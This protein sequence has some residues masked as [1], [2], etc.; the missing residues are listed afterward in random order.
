MQ[1]ESAQAT[2]TSKSSRRRNPT[3]ASY[4]GLG[5]ADEPTHLVKYAPTPN[6][7]PPP[8]Q[9]TAKRR[10][11]RNGKKSAS[12]KK[13]ATSSRAATSHRR[14]SD[15]LCV[16][17]SAAKAAT[18]KPDGS[19]EAHLPTFIAAGPLAESQPSDHRRAGLQDDSEENGGM[20]KRDDSSKHPPAF[21]FEDDDDD[22][23]QLCLDSD[24]CSRNADNSTC[25]SNIQQHPATSRAMI[26]DDDFDDDLMD[27]DL[28]DL[29]SDNVS[30]PGS[31]RFQ[32]SSPV[33]LDAWDGSGEPHQTPETSA[34]S[35]DAPTEERGNP[36]RASNEFVSPVTVMSRLLA[37]TGEE[38]RRPIVRSPFP[39][40]IRERSPIIGMSSNTVLRSCFRVGEAISQS[41]HAAKAGNNIL[42]ELYARVLIS[43]R[44][45]LQQRFTFCDLFHARP[46]YIQATYAAAIWKAV[47]LFEYDSARLMQRGRICRCI[48]TMKRNGKDWTLTVLNIW[49]ATWD[50]VQWVEGIV[51][52]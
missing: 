39:T 9:P 11:T 17:G 50:D 15:A 27:D 22:F 10:S 21:M 41:C 1:P 23:G 42:I 2:A 6:D 31:P 46:P 33:K 20:S 5:D 19:T 14:L 24:I 28:L 44:D 25:L 37:A 3:V 47:R 18:R 48:G 30:L 45:D 35:D 13:P 43:E 7:Q 49:E 4:L 16:T 34:I 40:A 36:S 26:N 8:S 38:G 32:S 52:S 12:R 51:N 29:L